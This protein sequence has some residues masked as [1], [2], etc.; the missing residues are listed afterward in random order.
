[1]AK[2]Q[3]NLLPDEPT[4]AREVA[5]YDEAP[6][7]EAVAA[8]KELRRRVLAAIAK[9]QLDNLNEIT[10]L[11]V[12]TWIARL[13]DVLVTAL[14]RRAFARAGAPADWTDRAGVIALGGY[15]RG[16]LNPHSDLDLLV[17]ALPQLGGLPAWLTAANAELQ[18]LLW[19]VQYTLGASLH[20]L[21]EL[22]RIVD[23]DFITATALIEQR[24]LLAG[25]PV[26]QALREAFV[27]FRRKR[28][29]A[30]L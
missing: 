21:P 25:E 4:L 12:V 24:P 2:A 26:A 15:G 20:G 27:R 10:G 5:R 9:S 14:T 8:L 30:F 18:A 22:E 1:M 16:E 11:D 13:A 17:V 6:R 29:T 7:A 19:D 3:P 23:E 28:G